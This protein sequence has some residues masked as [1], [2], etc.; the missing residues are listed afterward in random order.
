MEGEIGRGREGG[1]VSVLES[2]PRK[3]STQKSTLGSGSIMELTSGRLHRRRRGV[4][5]GDTLVLRSGFVPSS[6]IPLT[7]LCSFGQ[8]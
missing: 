6:P 5:E 2:T 3:G 4:D 7:S 1:G 8:N